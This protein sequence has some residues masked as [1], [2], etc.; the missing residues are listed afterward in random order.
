M[1]I[2][3]TD[4][5]TYDKISK[6]LIEK[7]NSSEAYKFYDYSTNHMNQS[8]N[9]NNYRKDT[10]MFEYNV[11]ENLKI[12]IFDKKIKLEFYENRPPHSRVILSSQ[13]EEIFS[14]LKTF[15]L[16]DLNKIDKSSWFSVLWSPVRSNKS[17]FNSTTFLSYYQFG[18]T[19]LDLYYRGFNDF[20]EIPIVGILPI[21]LDDNVW[22]NKITKGLY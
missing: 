12:L 3:L 10:L 6:E 7:R 5:M 15:D 17:H 4:T 11:T 20:M 16:I 18:Y 2:F 8:N 19:D 13:L 22:L 9:D 1:E 21:K 14:C